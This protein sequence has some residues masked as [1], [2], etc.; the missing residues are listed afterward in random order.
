MRLFLIDF[1]WL[2]QSDNDAVGKPEDNR[3]T[4][5]NNKISGKKGHD[6]DKRVI[7]IIRRDKQLD[8]VIQEKGPYEYRNYLSDP[9]EY[10]RH[11]ALLSWGVISYSVLYTS[12]HLIANSKGKLLTLNLSTAVKPVNRCVWLRNDLSR[13]V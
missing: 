5:K 1:F 6:K 2:T 10:N 4:D 7:E 8:A 11:E 12:P 13:S 9:P 3:S